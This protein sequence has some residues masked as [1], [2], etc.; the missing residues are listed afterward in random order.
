MT[1]HLS[2]RGIWVFLSAL[3]FIAAGAIA[4]H[5]VLLILGEIQVALLAVSFLTCVVA[6]HAL[7]RRYVSIAVLDEAGQEAF[8][9]TGHV[10][11]QPITVRIRIAND[12]W[13]P[14]FSFR[15]Q[16]YGADALELGEV[17]DRFQLASRTA[18]E[19]EFAIS[20]Q[21]SGRWMLHGFDVAVTDPLGLLEARDYLPSMHAF[22]CYPHA[23]RGASKTRAHRMEAMAI[24]SVGRHMVSQTGTGTVLRELRDYNPGDPLRNVAWKATARHRRLIARDYEREV[25]LSVYV[26]VDM[27]SSMR[28]GL[29]Q[30]QKLEHTIGLA[31]EIADTIIRGRDRA[32]VMTFDEKLY[33][34]IPP[35]MAPA[36]LHRIIRHLIGLNSVV[37]PE[38][39]ELDQVEVI[40]RVADYL[41]V[42]ER[43]DFRRGDDVEPRSGVNERLLA[44]WLDNILPLDADRFDSPILHDGILTEEPGPI[45][46]FARLRGLDIPYRVEARLGL[47]ERGLLAAIEQLIGLNRQ[48]QWIIVLSD[49][50]GV[51]NL[52]LVTR[53]V[54]LAAI[55]GHALQFLVPFTPAYY[56]EADEPS[57]TY[58]VARELFTIGERDERMKVIEHLRSLGVPVEFIQPGTSAARL[59]APHRA[60]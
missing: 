3:I 29:W 36:H 8:A 55:K 33:G 22:E 7:D 60:A 19:A 41:L 27:S 21:R 2:T 31:T 48:S 10:V 50:C 32:G 40:Q 11:D 39:T 42:Q 51:M 16:P 12:G 34:H 54:R 35:G 56:A 24:Q 18:A 57:E 30:G 23:A 13:M 4:E 5:Q 9:T 53:A 49:L 43:L 14:L 6:G 46:E 20:A 45:R 47:K 26:L 44:R 28:G 58:A 1:P 15:I 59:L 38:L 25:T 37:D 52:E 17:D